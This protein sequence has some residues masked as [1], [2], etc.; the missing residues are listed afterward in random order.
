MGNLVGRREGSK[1]GSSVGNCVGSFVC[2]VERVGFRDGR[3]L[4]KMYGTADG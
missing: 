3:L 2:R 1:V 4:G